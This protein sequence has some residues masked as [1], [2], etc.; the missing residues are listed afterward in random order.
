MLRGVMFLLFATACCGQV[1]NSRSSGRSVWDWPRFLGPTGDG[2]SQERGNLTQWP[3][4]GLRILWQTKLG[5]GYAPPTI[6]RGRLFHFD[7][8]PDPKSKG[9]V[10]RLTCR[11]SQTGAEIWR[12]EYP[13]QYDDMF[14]Y[15]NGP[16]CAPIVDDERVYIHG[17]EGMVHCVSANDGRLIW[18]V[19]THT[20]YHVIQ[21]FFGVGSCPLVFEDLLLVPVGGSPEGSKADE[22][23]R[24]KGNGT[25]IV[26]FDKQ[27]GHERYRVGDELSSYSTP[28]VAMIQN[29]PV[30][31]YF[32]RGGLL[33]FDPRKGE[34]LFHYPWR[35]RILESVNAANPVVVGDQIL[36]S[37]CYGVG[38]ALIKIKGREVQEV[39]TDMGKGRAASLRCHWNTPI[40]VKG[41]VYGCS[42]R[43]T[44]EA[45]LRCIDWATGKIVWRQR[46]MTRG[47]LLY[48][49]DH[50]LY[51]CEDGLLVLIKVNP[52]KYEEIAR[53]DLG[54]AGLLE[55]PCWAAPVLSNG[56][57]YLRGN[58]RLICAEL[59]PHKKP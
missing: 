56:L 47:S 35:A 59:I 18:K 24:L 29:R 6:S 12:F 42:G 26:A 40:H 8:L 39:W 49:D 51:L 30:G 14:G 13:F 25:A 7:A 41:F 57:L 52:Q 32:A 43:H 54:S 23:M 53:W 4:S 45:E 46:G 3:T 36:L 22:F 50:F 37:E 31:L 20:R 34:V 16:R 17:V 38:S 10:A 1:P 58:G 11:N 28:I 27:T 44:N 9:H 21:N 33:G 48:V 55:Y 5:L 15:D 2:I 19:N